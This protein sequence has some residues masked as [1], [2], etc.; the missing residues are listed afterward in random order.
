MISSSHKSERWSSR[1][2]LIIHQWF[3]NTTYC[4]DVDVVVIVVVSLSLSLSL[5]MRVDYSTVLT[6]QSYFFHFEAVWSMHH[7]HQQYN[8]GMLHISRL[9]QYSRW[10][11]WNGMALSSLCTWDWN[12]PWFIVVCT[13]VVVRTDL[14]CDGSPCA[15]IATN[16]DCPFHH[17]LVISW[18]QSKMPGTMVL[19]SKSIRYGHN[20]IML[21]S[22]MCC[23]I[24]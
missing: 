12:N 11:D 23:W 19:A 6:C 1:L 24:E 17:H 8:L 4:I 21:Y 20:S 14:Y 2:W 3:Q 5:S 18:I 7:I 13:T 15:G 10:M 9:D 16:S 22:I